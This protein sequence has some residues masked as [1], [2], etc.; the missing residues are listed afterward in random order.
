MTCDGVSVA[1]MGVVGML[2]VVIVVTRDCNGVNAESGSLE[3]CG[4]AGCIGVHDAVLGEVESV[5]EDDGVMSVTLLGKCEV[6]WSWSRW[7]CW[8]CVLRNAR[9]RGRWGLRR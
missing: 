1:E 7:C 9:R 8:R 2:F 3:A 4:L 6:G 5:R